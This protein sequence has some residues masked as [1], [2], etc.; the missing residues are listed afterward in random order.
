MTTTDFSYVE[1][2][3]VGRVETFAFSHQN[4][5]LALAT[6][7]G[8][9]YLFDT[10]SGSL[11]HRLSARTAVSAL[12]FSR[13]GRLIA[14][15]E[16]RSLFVWDEPYTSSC[17]PFWDES[18]GNFYPF[19]IPPPFDSLRYLI[20]DPAYMEVTQV[21]FSDDEKSVAVAW[22]KST[23]GVAAHSVSNYWTHGVTLGS[24]ER[25]GSWV[26]SGSDFAVGESRRGIGALD[27]T[28]FGYSIQHW[29]PT[30]LTISDENHVA[31]A[32]GNTVKIKT[33]RG[34]VSLVK[35]WAYQRGDVRSLTFGP[36]NK[37]IIVDGIEV[38]LDDA[39]EF[40]KSR[41]IS[42]DFGVERRS[43]A[44][45]GR[46]YTWV[47]WKGDPIVCVPDD[48]SWKKIESRGKCLAVSHRTGNISFFTIKESPLNDG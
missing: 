7:G 11:R 24:V 41:N 27:L 1:A 25:S 3:G 37:S 4:T 46:S 48:I 20:T 30:A 44:I 22:S 38:S 40:E 13:T 12:A 15:G 26:Q 10:R 33:Q 36:G 21:V 35:R 6:T 28:G 14:G 19:K 45:R 23:L 16:N 17:V 2:G 29:A 9:V 34:N 18:S 43:G 5:L 42:C 8:N 32:W 39:D 47:T 31:V